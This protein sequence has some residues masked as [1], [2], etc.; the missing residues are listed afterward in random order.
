MALTMGFAAR[1]DAQTPDGG[2]TQARRRRA[3]RRGSRRPSGSRRRE[4][5][6]DPARRGRH[7]RAS[8]SRRGLGA[9]ARAPRL[10][11]S[12]LR[13]TFAPRNT[14][15]SFRRAPST[16]FPRRRSAAAIPSP[17]RRPFAS[18]A[19]VFSAPAVSCKQ[20]A[21][22]AVIGFGGYPT[23]PPIIAASSLKIPTAI[24][25]QN[26]V[27]GRANRLLSR[28]VDRIALSFQP[29][30]LLRPDAEVQSPRDRD[31]GARCRA[32]L[33]RRALSA[34]GTGSAPA[35][36][37]LRRQSG[38]AL[39]LRGAAAGAVCCRPV[40]GRLTVVQQAREED[41]DELREAYKEG[42][43]R[44]ACCD[45]LPRSARADRHGPSRRRPLG[46]LDRCRADG[47]RPPLPA[48]AAAACP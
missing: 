15:S 5:A 34:A 12:S 41:L 48:G 32:C 27:M 33:S 26:A 8:L 21:P 35:A 18:S 1:A 16:A 17:W 37:D 14:A 38:R 13:P 4:R 45:L 22:H 40:R 28:V 7:G 43:H 36:A 44:R 6:P 31:A 29:T 39:L 47:D 10:S 11:R 2:A 46:R 42:R 20:I 30:K 25:E 24:H 19:S 23:L 9:G 3:V